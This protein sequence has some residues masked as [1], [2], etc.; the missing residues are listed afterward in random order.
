MI[1]APVSA[2]GRVIVIV[3][4]VV[5]VVVIA[6][7]VFH[8]T[9]SRNSFEKL[10]KDSQKIGGPRKQRKSANKVRPTEAKQQGFETV[11]LIVGV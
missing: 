1:P 6:V 7:V 3:V 9:T 2:E 8:E 5:V 4:A 11:E 10:L